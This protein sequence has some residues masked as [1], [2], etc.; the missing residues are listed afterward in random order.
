M[1]EYSKKSKFNKLQLEADRSLG[2]IT[3]GIA[4]NYVME[5]FSE[6]KSMPSILKISQYPLPKEKIR[7]IYKHCDKIMVVEEGYPLVEEI[8]HDYFSDDSKIIGKLTGHLPLRGNSIRILLG[9]PSVLHK[10]RH[11]KFRTLFRAGHHNYV[12]VADILTCST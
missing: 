11:K 8:L 12:K 4:Y 3:T 2:I 10:K 6:A 7:E 1:L 5:N 9:K